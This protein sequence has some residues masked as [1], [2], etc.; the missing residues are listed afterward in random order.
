M[1][2][3]RDHQLLY[4]A[5]IGDGYHLDVDNRTPV[6][7]AAGAV[8]VSSA[9]GDAPVDAPDRRRHAPAFDLDHACALTP[10]GTL[11]V[12]HL[13]RSAWE[14]AVAALSNA[15]LVAAA[16]GESDADL[17]R[18]FEQV[19]RVEDPRP[20]KHML[21]AAGPHLDSGWKDLCA[22]VDDLIGDVPVAP[23]ATMVTPRPLRFT[24]PVMLLPSTSNFHLLADAD[25]EWGDYSDL[26]SGLA[27]NLLE[28]G[29][30]NASQERVG[31][32][33]RVPWVQKYP[34]TASPF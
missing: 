16:A 19:G 15:R 14:D 8:L 32:H 10:E 31:T 18:E 25:L 13:S 9:Q 27:G 24:V 1:L 21:S 17:A 4:A 20:L 6:R 7:R 2:V 22:L 33:L 3:A 28:T 11:W 34:S 12:D 26:L 29:F 5:A 30:V 23:P